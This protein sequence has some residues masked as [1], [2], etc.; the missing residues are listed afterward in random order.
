MILLSYNIIYKRKL[1]RYFLKNY[2]RLKLKKLI[3]IV[4]CY[5]CI[6]HYY[7]IY[8]NSNKISIS[9]NGFNYTYIFNTV[10]SM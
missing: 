4:Q 1:F 9:S 5:M 10:Q 3:R 6:I 8:N 2:R 7:N